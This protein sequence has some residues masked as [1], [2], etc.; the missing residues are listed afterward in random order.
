MVA[1]TPHEIAREAVQQ[2]TTRKLPPTP[3]NY[4][5]VYHEVAGTLPLRP[6]PLDALRKL[7]QALPDRSPGQKRLKA[8]CEAAVSQHSWDGLQRALVEYASLGP[9]PAPAAQPATAGPDRPLSAHSD[10]DA[11]SAFPPDVLD[12]MARIIEHTLPTVGNH[13]AKLAEQGVE[14]TAYLRLPGHEP[15]ALR[16]ALANFAFRL[17]FVAEEQ[18]VVQTTLLELVR[19]MFE[20]IRDP[21]PVVSEAP[22]SGRRTIISI[23]GAVR[24]AMGAILR[25]N[26]MTWIYGQDVGSKGGVMQATKGLYE[27]FPRQ[28]RDAP[29]NEPFIIGSA[30]GFALHEGATALPEIQFSDYSLNTL[31]WLVYLGNLLWTS[32]GTARANVIVRLPVEPLHGGAVYHS[33]CMEGFYASIPGLTIVAPTT[34]RDMY[35]LLRSAADYS[36]PVVVFES[37]GLYRMTLGDAFPNE[38][39]DAEEV[40]K[41]KRAIAFEG[42]RP[43]LPD[44]FRV[45]LGK[46]DVLRAGTDLTLVTWGR[47]A[48]FAR[49]AVATL[50][51]QGV[52]V[53]LIDL[54][55]IVPPDLDTVRRS[56]DKTGRL[57]VAHEDRVFAS[58]GR[59]IQGAMIESFGERQ[60]ATRVVGQ[61]PV[62]G[63]PQNVGLEDALAMN[64]A[65]VLAAAHQVLA[66][67]IGASAPTERAA[68]RSDGP[69]LWTPNRHFVA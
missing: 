47:C 4:Q 19:L 35:G 66:Q 26:P 13:D 39:T 59:E 28:V 52:S 2:L 38:P 25:N 7:A 68:A 53:E 20:N 21:Y 60:I 63:M 34:S 16:K 3:E 69:I 67:R 41:L 22:R 5:N 12:Q 54:R 40:R 8:Q 17:S 15:L 58:L 45:P 49:E 30:I 62:P 55:T 29:I 65:R 42:H 43:D 64:P 6:F 18:T 61:E 32:N 57:L 50:A 10:T 56:V 1:R 11:P 27:D 31:H 33:M 23:N 36:G 37:K 51:E 9:A 44:D 14:L 48:L 46:A 24:A